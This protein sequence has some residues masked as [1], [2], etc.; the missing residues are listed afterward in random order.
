MSAP[1]TRYL[2]KRDEIVAAATD[3]L[4]EDGVGGFTLAGVAKRLGMHPASLA[5]YFKK[6]EDLAAT[7]LLSALERLQTLLDDAA[8]EATPEAQLT[9]FVEATFALRRR[10][11]RGE[12]QAL[13]SFNEIR[14]IEEP[15]RGRVLAAFGRLFESVERIFAGCAFLSSDGCKA[16]AR[17]VIEQ[18]MW[19]RVW[20]EGYDEAD[21][22]RAAAR[23]CD[24][25][26]HGIAAPGRGRSGAP[27][28]GPELVRDGKEVSRETFLLAATEL[29]NALGYRGASVD[30]ISA[31]LNVTKGSF[32]YH[33]ADKNDLVVACFER[34]FAIMAEAQAKAAARGG[35]GWERL[36]H[37]AG[38]LIAGNASG[39]KRLLRTHALSALPLAA[40]APMLQAFERVAHRFAGTI[41]DGIADGSIRPIDPLIAAELVMATI[42]LSAYIDVWA[43]GLSGPEIFSAYAVPALTGLFHREARP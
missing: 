42:N 43:T 39:R 24:L 22:P 15:H 5:Y 18:V 29:I 32:Y 31:E 40:R 16:R 20:L 30:R 12:E 11:R 35:T 17:F 36:C 37:A 14:L 7:C 4:N 3:V 26:L 6:K 34:T 10:V 38:R 19:A 23:L 2:A 41:S 9:R 25:L 8:R 33:N 13:A 1:Q 28:P 21:Y 27:S